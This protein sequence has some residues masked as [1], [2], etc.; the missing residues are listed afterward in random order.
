MSNNLS[1]FSEK[2]YNNNDH[3]SKSDKLLN[4]FEDIH[5]H[6]YAN[7]GL[8]SQEAFV[9]MLDILFVKVFDEKS[10]ESSQFSISASEYEIV[11]KGGKSD[12]F[13]K[14]FN[15]LYKKT[16][17]Y[18]SD[19]IDKKRGFKLKNSTLAY[20]V[21]KLQ[22]INLSESSSDVKGLAFQK[23]LY[24]KQR[25]ERGQFFTP[26]PIVKL[27]VN[28]LKP[29]TKDLILDPACGSGGFLSLVAHYVINNTHSKSNKKVTDFI[30]SRLLGIEINQL[31]AKV[32][33]MRMLLEHN[34]HSNICVADSLSDWSEL[35]LELSKCINNGGSFEGK[36]DLILTNP[37]FGSKGKIRDESVLRRFS[38]AHKWI[39]KSK[40]YF[41]SEQIQ[42]GQ[43]PDI[44]FIERCIDFL[45]DN[46]RMAIVLP[47]GIFENPSLEY[48]R[49]YIKSRTSILAVVKL[50]YETFVPFGT[51]VK[52]S[53]LFIQKSPR[54]NLDRNNQ[55]DGSI[56]FG[57]INKLGYA[58][59][60]NGS[61]TY[62]RD[63]NGRLITD[64][65]GSPKLDEDVSNVIEDFDKFQAGNFTNGIEDRYFI[66]SSDCR[67]RLDY[68]FYKPSYRKL[69]IMLNRNGEHLGNVVKLVKRI[70]PKKKYEGKEVEYVEL[71][72]IN[73]EYLEITNS[74]NMF[75]HDLPSRATYILKEGDIVTAVAGNSIG[76]R[77]HMTALVSK[78]YDGAIA[79][80][81]LR[82][83]KPVGDLDPYYLLYFL[84]TEIFLKQVLRFRTGAAIPAVSDDDLL[85][86]QIYLPDKKKQQQI[87]DVVKKGF[88]LRLRSRQL[89]DEVDIGVP[90]Y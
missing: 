53:L 89:L 88:E 6:I 81:G 41:S 77:K 85:R 83:L 60:K 18:F 30:E 64:K 37:P 38:L 1:L 5:N 75:F 43:V 66:K 44:L 62:L 67:S 82:I 84:R 7:D 70:V 13:F 35:N 52:A 47:N 27:C 19:V 72:D 9:E 12:K 57:V 36:F 26:E 15:S 40:G 39:S 73:S 28:F 33:K 56:F 68:D 61:P 4:I 32:A 51:G 54:G 42:N 69:E 31:A 59:N 90:S 14:R 29:S 86:I 10:V 65:D 58:G 55:N 48:V 74:T 8:S 17:E 11:Q 22:T 76:S 50:P 46:G 71:A 45:K 23:F 87:A 79:T 78:A 24:S 49:S 16:A 20:I 3:L 21:N 80:N 2:S 34:G 63:S 25:S